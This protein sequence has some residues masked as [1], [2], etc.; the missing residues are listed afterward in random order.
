ML[1]PEDWTFEIEG[2][3]G[4]FDGL[5]SGHTESDLTPGEYLINEESGG[6]EGYVASFAGC[7]GGV[8]DLA[9]GEDH[10]CTITNTADPG[11]ITIDKSVSFTNAQIIISIA[12]FELF[13]DNGDGP[14]QLT[15]E[16]T[17]GS[18]PPGTYTVSENYVGGEAISFNPIYSGD[19]SDDGGHRNHH[20]GSGRQC[21]L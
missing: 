11:E 2:P 19:C 5:L 16:V 3:S 13:V 15:D 6:P 14:I 8:V 21:Q 17:M 7:D 18:L 9:A 1:I 10:V 20:S 12:D 4:V